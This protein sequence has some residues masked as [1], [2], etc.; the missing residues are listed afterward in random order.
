MLSKNRLIIGH[1]SSQSM[2]GKT[3]LDVD[4]E[5]EQ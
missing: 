1:Y 3:C 2:L 5:G 4:F